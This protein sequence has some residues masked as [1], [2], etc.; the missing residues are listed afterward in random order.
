MT[1]FLHNFKHDKEYRKESLLLLGLGILGTIAAYGIIF[2][3]T[4]IGYLM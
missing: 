3:G 1:D 2:I 4:T